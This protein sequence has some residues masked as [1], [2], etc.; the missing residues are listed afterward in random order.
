MQTFPAKHPGSADGA[1]PENPGTENSVPEVSSVSPE[2]CEVS[3]DT[4]TRHATDKTAF[5][6]PDAGKASGAEHKTD[7]PAPGMFDSH[8]HYYDK[9]FDALPGGADALLEKLFESGEV[10]KIINVAT[11]PENTE[12]C[13]KMA[14]RYPGMYV[15]AGIHPED[16][17]A[18]PDTDAALSALYERISPEKVRRRDK[19][20][21]IGE[22]GLDYY[23][24]PHDKKKQADFFD[25]QM[26]FAA[27]LGLPV[28]IHDR[29]AHGDCFETVLRYPQVRGVFHSYSGSAEMARELIRRGWYI[30]FSGVVTF[31]NASRVREVA[32]SV[33]ADRLLIETDCPYLAPH[34]HRGE[35]N[36][37][38]LMR[39][40]AEVLAGVHGMSVA[41]LVGR[42]KENAE[43][44]FGLQES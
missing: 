11:N 18:Y 17:E 24:K 28:I 7:F 33:P 12:L 21:A 35:I 37:S 14:A 40:T 36:H 15:A 6:S 26:A 29:E 3:G 13:V 23:W 41:E 22:I 27:G 42:T 20:V 8:A 44:L 43:T 2:T 19:I 16:C 1:L 9:K 30:S 32:A 10:E 25:A 38:G 39:Y 34:P 5:V 4:A 31:K